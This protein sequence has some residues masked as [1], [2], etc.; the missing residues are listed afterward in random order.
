MATEMANPASASVRIGQAAELL[1]VTVDTIRRCEDLGRVTTVRTSGGQRLVALRDV[2]RLLEE[3][4]H[5]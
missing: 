2:S 5:T 1:G 4:R 3:R